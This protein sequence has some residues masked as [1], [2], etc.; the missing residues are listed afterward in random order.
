MPTR[1]LAI[2]AVLAAFAPLASAQIS[3]VTQERFV[4]ASSSVTSGPQI[5]DSDEAL[6]NGPYLHTANAAVTGVAGADAI[7]SAFQDTALTATIIRGSLSASTQAHT[8]AT[9]DVG[10][11]A[12]QSSILYIFN[13]TAATAI[14]FT[15]NGELAF[16]GQDPNGEPSDLYGISSVQLLDG[17]TEDPISG[18]QMNAGSPAGTNSAHFSGTLPAGQYVILAK[19]QTHVYSA[20]LLGPPPRSGSGTATTSFTL[21]VGSGGHCGTADFNCDGDIGTDS[22][23]AAFFACLAGSCPSL[24]CTNSADFNG[25]GDTGTDSDIEA[26]FRVLSGGTC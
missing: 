23:I 25:D 10:E 24:P 19:A 21:T 3:L 9:F 16:I 8:G 13:L 17:V 6:N 14:Q 20:D 5:D 2:A 7:G 15:A 1:S 4:L 26:F 12:G 18:F 11:S 22:D